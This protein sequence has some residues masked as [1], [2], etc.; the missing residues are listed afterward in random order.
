MQINLD[1]DIYEYQK[2]LT[3]ILGADGNIMAE[4]KQQKIIKRLI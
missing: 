2:I 3:Y 1:A 4:K